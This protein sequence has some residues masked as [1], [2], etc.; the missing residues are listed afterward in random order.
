MVI[1][2]VMY[3]LLCKLLYRLLP[4]GPGIEDCKIWYMI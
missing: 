1:D 3:S 4:I 2:Y